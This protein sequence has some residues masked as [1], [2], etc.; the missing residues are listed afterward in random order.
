[1]E[2][3]DRL[4]TLKES[5]SI[6]NSLIGVVYSLYMR[7]KYFKGLKVKNEG[8]A[9]LKKDVRGN[10]NYL[11]I[12]RH[13]IIKDIRIHIR[14][15]NNRIVFGENCRIEKG[16]SFWA[17]GSGIEIRIGNNT[18]IQYNSHFCAQE[19]KISIVLG[20]DCML[21]NNI[22]I[23]TSD[24][25]S[26]LN[27]ITKERINPPGNVIIGNHVWIAA[28]VIV[29]KGVQLGDNSIVGTRSIVTKSVPSNC[30]AVGM[31]AKTI[32]ENVTWDRRRIA[33]GKELSE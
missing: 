1:M 30:L 6:I 28:Q 19:D 5:S 32:K 16:C 33:F 25:H 15:N 9:K 21:S 13:S 23:R 4:K 3:K 27:S 29:L 18:S 12:G 7:I 20:D 14:G 8:R 17:E 24:S 22:I 2:F 26:V 31:P 10:N 11:E